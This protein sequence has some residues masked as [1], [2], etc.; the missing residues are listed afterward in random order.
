M[1]KIDM[2]LQRFQ[3]GG[4]SAVELIAA[5]LIIT[6]LAILVVPAYKGLVK[7][8]YTAKCTSNLRQIGSAF[9]AYSGDNGG[10]IPP[11]IEPKP[12]QPG[13][14][15]SGT[16][17]HQVLRRGGYFGPTAPED[18]NKQRAAVQRTGVHF[19]PE[20]PSTGTSDEAYGMRRWR[21]PGQSIDTSQTLV[22]LTNPSDFFILTDSYETTTKKQGYSLGTGQSGWRIR[23]T[24]SGRANTLFADGHVALMDRA[25]FD[26]VPARQS[27][28]GYT[29]EKYSY[30][31]SGETSE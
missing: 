27:A 21:A 17:W 16:Y 19:C 26:S 15:V 9:F 14:Y 22:S 5:L 12:D 29:M 30:W 11:R 1:N 20:I 18:S 7:K 23:F 8:G 2:R 28:Y 25:Y 24:H 31:P 3:R 10:K 13:I 6:I 4:F